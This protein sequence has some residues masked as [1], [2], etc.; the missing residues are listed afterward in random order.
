MAFHSLLSAPRTR[1]LR[2]CKGHYTVGPGP[3]LF[4]TSNYSPNKFTRPHA[5]PTPPTNVVYTSI[6][7][8]E[9]WA[10]I[11]H[12]SMWIFPRDDLA[13]SPPNHPPPSDLAGTSLLSRQSVRQI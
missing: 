7:G 9:N 5:Q 13:P 6:N 2:Q 4:L 11:L 8:K 3:L 12:L 10:L 1:P